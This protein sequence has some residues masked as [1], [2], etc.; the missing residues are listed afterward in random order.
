MFVVISIGLKYRLSEIIGYRYTSKMWQSVQHY[1]TITKLEILTLIFWFINLLHGRYPTKWK[2][3][4]VWNQVCKNHCM[5][6]YHDIRV[7][8]LSGVASCLSQ[9][10][11]IFECL[12]IVAM[13]GH[14]HHS[15]K[16]IKKYCHLTLYH[17]FLQRYMGVGYSSPTLY[18]HTYLTLDYCDN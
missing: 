16:T 15:Y 10:Q 7:F 17:V 18:V 2:N 13:F 9:Q 6:L 14:W 5:A 8:G 3:F 12:M 1:N 4:K 11:W